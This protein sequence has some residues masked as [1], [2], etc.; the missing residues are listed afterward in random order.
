MD[1]ALVFLMYH[2]LELP[3][4]ALCQGEPGYIRYVLRASDFH[5]QIQWLKKAGWK[6]WNVS[7]ALTF[8]AS[9]GVA[10]TFDDG[11]E[12]DLLTAAP[13]LR[14]ANFAATFYIT[15][16]FLNRPGYLCSSQVQELVR[17]GFEIGCHSMTHAYLSDLDREGL[18][19]EI[20]VPK[21]KLEQITGRPVKH[22]S[23]PGGRWN[24]TV[25]ETAKEA[26][27]E[28]VTTSRNC[29][30]SQ[31]ADLFSLGRV[32]ILRSTNLDTFHQ[33]CRAQNLW[34][35]QLKDL[36]RSAGKKLIGNRGYD[37]IRALLLKERKSSS[38]TSIG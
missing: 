35:L 30:N 12:T 1:A 37:A 3:N 25:A 20:V 19:K 15:L 11:C 10:I 6:G 13:V 18:H 33:I 9:P 21:L 31:R 29:A 34:R 4:R 2:E 28:S 36:A 24:R 5:S 38:K 8:P 23:C 32:A 22:F 26:G 27:Y 7:E 14:E 17:L 16:G